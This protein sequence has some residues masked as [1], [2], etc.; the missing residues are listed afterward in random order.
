MN[1]PQQNLPSGKSKILIWILISIVMILLIGGGLFVWYF[2]S[3]NQPDATS[4]P[5]SSLKTTISTQKTDTKT[6]DKTGA[7]TKV[8]IP[9]LTETQLKNTNYKTTDI[10]TTFILT[11][12]IYEYTCTGGPKCQVNFIES[13][14]AN[15]DDDPELEAIVILS[16]SSGGTGTF[17]DLVTVDNNNGQPEFIDNINLG[18]VD[19]KSVSV[20]NKKITVKYK[21]YAPSDQHC[22]PTLDVIK[23]YQIVNRE[24]KEV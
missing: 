21:D 2:L 9:D 14:F 23:N 16:W 4:S 17:E 8:G 22:C 24:I 7:E 20:V 6:S 18:D 3:Q 10:S 11:N 19:Y 13:Q 15:L 5:A 12:G 1:Q